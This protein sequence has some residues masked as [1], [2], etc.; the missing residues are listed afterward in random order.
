MRRCV[1]V[2]ILACSLEA[3]V[4][5]FCGGFRPTGREPDLACGRHLPLCTTGIFW[6]L[7][8]FVLGFPMTGCE[9]YLVLGKASAC[10]YQR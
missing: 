3:V 8:D 9:P 4:D 10:L 1:Q 6:N 5:S 7:R 2:Q